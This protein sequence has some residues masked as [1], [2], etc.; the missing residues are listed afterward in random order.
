MRL[1]S[2]AVSPHSNSIDYAWQDV[3]DYAW[4]DVLGSLC[5]LPSKM[6]VEGLIAAARSQR[7]II[8]IPIHVLHWTQNLEEAELGRWEIRN[9][10]EIT[11]VFSIFYH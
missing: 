10:A 9:M 1:S 6:V 2:R 3:I 5:I 8:C 4:R 11:E 7:I